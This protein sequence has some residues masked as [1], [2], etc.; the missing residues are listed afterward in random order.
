MKDLLVLAQRVC[1]GWRDLV[2]GSIQLRRALFLEP[3]DCGGVTH[4]PEYNQYNGGFGKTE[5]DVSRYHVFANPLVNMLFNPAASKRDPFSLRDVMVDWK[6]GQTMLLN[7]SWVNMPSTQPPVVETSLRFYLVSA[8]LGGVDLHHHVMHDNQGLAAGQIIQ[9]VPSVWSNMIIDSEGHS[10]CYRSHGPDWRDDTDLENLVHHDWT[11]ESSLK[12][13]A[14]DL[15]TDNHE[16]KLSYG[17]FHKIPRDPEEMRD[18]VMTR[19]PSLQGQGWYTVG[20]VGD[21][22]DTSAKRF[23]VME[24]Q[25]YLDSPRRLSLPS[26]SEAIWNH[27]TI[28][29]E[30]RSNYP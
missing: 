30:K 28:L 20:W 24:L 3:A 9:E 11:Q 10:C 25:I 16:R 14:E 21:I 19:I 5:D 12:I 1:T 2:Q 6:R 7:A 8:G 26:T 4:F 29:Q 15:I 23:A 22:L 18:R 13:R 27:L 17:T